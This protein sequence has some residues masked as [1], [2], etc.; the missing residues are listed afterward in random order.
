[1]R[2]LPTAWAAT[3]AAH[4]PPNR[5]STRRAA[6]S[7]ATRPAWKRPKP[8]SSRPSTKH[9]LICSSR[10]LNEKDPHSTGVALIL[11]PGR[12]AWA[13]CGDSRL[14]HFRGATTKTRTRDHSFVEDLLRHGK[15]SP[16]EA[17][18]YPN[19]NVL[20]TSLGGD[21]TP[22][23]ETEVCTDFAAGDSFLLC[24]DG[25]WGYFEDLE[26]AR[27]IA[28]LPARAAAERLIALARQ[29]A[30]GQGDNCSLVLL[31]LVAAGEQAPAS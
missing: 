30:R 24:S 18:L 9:L 10:V 31:K 2:W 25:L 13:W 23:I 29:R 22:R 14:F 16:Q 19:R 3:P 7:S 27:I 17:A 6:T 1:V 20:I 21:E 4:S 8:C 11:E 26:L 12:A 5:S 28:P 15:I